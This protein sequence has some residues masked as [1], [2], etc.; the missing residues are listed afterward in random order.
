[1]GTF[2][3]CRDGKVAASGICRSLEKYIPFSKGKH[4]FVVQWNMSGLQTKHTFNGGKHTPNPGMISE[5]LGNSVVT[6]VPE[7]QQPLRVG[8]ESDGVSCSRCGQLSS[9]AHA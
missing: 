2:Q 8:G 4:T 3:E 9:S 6:E 7:S 5:Q 1:M